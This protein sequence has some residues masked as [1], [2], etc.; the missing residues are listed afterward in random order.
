[1]NMGSEAIFEGEKERRSKT[2]EKRGGQNDFEEYKKHTQTIKTEEERT[3]TQKSRQTARSGKPPPVFEKSNCFS[4]AR[5]CLST[6]RARRDACG[7]HAA[8]LAACVR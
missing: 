6:R 8:P 7:N 2:S 3:H 5:R 4:T 1:M